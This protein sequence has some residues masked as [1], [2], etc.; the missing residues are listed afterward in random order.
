MPQCFCAAVAAGAPGAN[1][2]R[3][4]KVLA[5]GDSLTAGLYNK[6]DNFAAYGHVLADVLA[7][8][9]LATEV[10]VCGLSGLTAV[11]MTK[12][13]PSKRIRDCTDRI[14]KGI[15]QILL[16]DSSFDLAL[17]MA[18]TNDMS[19]ST[20]AAAIATSV[21]SLHSACHELGVPTVMLSVPPNELL[22]QPPSAEEGKKLSEKQVKSARGRARYLDRWTN[23][24]ELLR[25]WAHGAGRTD[26]VVLFVD[27]AALVPYSEPSPLWE[28]DGL[29]LSPEGSKRLGEG[30]APLI[31]PLLSESAAAAAVRGDRNATLRALAPMPELVAPLQPLSPACAS[32]VVRRRVLAFGDSLTAGYNCYGHLFTPY[33]EG[34]VPAL[35]P[36]I[37]AEVWLCGL[38]GM[39]A[40]DM[41]N[42][43]D[44]AEVSD[45]LDRTGK[46]L[47]RMVK[48]EG[49]FDLAVIMAG[50][51][52]LAEDPEPEDLLEHIVVMHKACHKAGVPTVALGVP[53]SRAASGEYSLADPRK[54]VNKLLRAWSR[55]P[56]NAKARN[57]RPGIISFV[58]TDELMPYDR[59]DGNWEADGLHFSRAGCLRFGERLAKLLSPLLAAEPVGGG[60]R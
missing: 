40:E 51:N 50:T 35:L 8:G 23:T 56:D 17:I 43:L 27:V 25:E 3:K 16:E 59:A 29:H 13:L 34:L 11:Q 7:A 15:Q 24:N 60:P 9:G 21:Q 26:G 31:A 46:G 33:A 32:G 45:C 44:K 10:W 19:T 36:G 53:P 18:G 49:P 57:G 42:D 37:E 5:Y 2:G 22:A 14:G 54:T 12:R 38:S 30:L 20:N 4:R 39:T 41:A 47:R 1:S 58:D 48:D 28:V 55:G 52:D 6:G